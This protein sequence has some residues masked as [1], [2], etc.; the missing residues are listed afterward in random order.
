[1][2]VV[3]VLVVDDHPVFRDG[4]VAALAREPDLEIVGA[5]QSAKIGLEIARTQPLDLAITDVMMPD[6]T[7]ISFTA[8]LHQLQPD[9]TILALSM[10]DEPVVI[11]EIL[12]AGANGYAHKGQSVDALI[13]AIRAVI[14]GEMY[15]PPDVPQRGREHGRGPSRSATRTPHEARA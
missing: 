13:A 10:V 6:T 12:R 8:E 9:C 1:M 7:G 5:V 4:L 3:K 14:A 2:S 15:L 11:A